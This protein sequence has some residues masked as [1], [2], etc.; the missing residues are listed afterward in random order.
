MYDRSVDGGMDRQEFRE[1]LESL[2]GEDE[3]ALVETI[4]RRV[5]TLSGRHVDIQDRISESDRT[6]QELQQRLQDVEAEIVRQ[7]DASVEQDVDSIEDVEDLP[8]DAGVE[9]DPDLVEEVQAVRQQARDNY[10]STAET[11][12]DLQTE[13]NENTEELELY[14]E[15]LA[16]VEE[17]TLTPDEARQR[18][19][20]A[21]RED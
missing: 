1:T 3:A 6:R 14:G 10:Q 19:L 8:E 5:S 13:L 11:G 12:S 20:A 16:G 7:A 15:V 18:L 9:F 17:G 2:D 4:R 21:L